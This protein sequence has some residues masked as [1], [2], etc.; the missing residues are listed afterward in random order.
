MC[1]GPDRGPWGMDSIRELRR[2]GGVG[3]VVG[4]DYCLR[5]PVLRVGVRCGSQA[6]GVWVWIAYPAAA[7]GR[8]VFVCACM[9]APLLHEM[10]GRAGL[11]VELPSTLLCYTEVWAR[12]M[13]PSASELGRVQEHSVCPAIHSDLTASSVPESD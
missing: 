6:P 4:L 5:I 7:P 12:D 13:L 3:V 8:G 10:T 11:H 9:C 2:G 1:P